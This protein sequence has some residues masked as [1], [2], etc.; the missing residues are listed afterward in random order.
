[1][2]LLNSFLSLPIR[3]CELIRASIGNRRVPSAQFV[4][5]RRHSSELAA[6][7]DLRRHRLIR[8]FLAHQSSYTP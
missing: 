2:K 8:R 5:R 4:R 7:A 1:V 6:G 3:I